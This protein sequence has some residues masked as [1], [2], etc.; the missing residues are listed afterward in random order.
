MDKA[1]FYTIFRVMESAFPH[2]KPSAD[3][4]QVYFETLKDIPSEVLKAACL[5]A[6]TDSEFLP[7]IAKIRKCAASLMTGETKTG[8]EA[9]GEMIAGMRARIGY[10]MPQYSDPLI[11]RTVQAIGWEAICAAD[12]DD[13]ATRAQ[14]IKVYDALRARAEEHARELPQVAA[15]AERYRIAPADTMRLLAEKL[16]VKQ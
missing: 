3:T 6:L 11:S 1:E 8:G 16:S 14:F 2:S 12:E 7:T 13:F 9:W 10:G 15:V 4:V 5:K